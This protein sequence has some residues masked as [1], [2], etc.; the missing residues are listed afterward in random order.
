MQ[1]IQRI[2]RRPKKF[3]LTTALIDRSSECHP[4]EKEVNI[5]QDRNSCIG[6]NTCPYPFCA[7][8]LAKATSSQVSL[9]MESNPPASTRASVLIMRYCPIAIANSLACSFSCSLN[10]TKRTGLNNMALT[11]SSTGREG[12]SCLG[13]PLTKEA[14]VFLSMAKP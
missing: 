12:V 13:Y 7:N 4:L 2:K 3:C 5:S 9:L 11:I 14:F 6:A 1:T 8:I 10:G